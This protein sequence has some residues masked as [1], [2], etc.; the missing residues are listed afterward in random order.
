M[1]EPPVT[2]G[3]SQLT[4]EE[5]FWWLAAMTLLGAFGVVA[6]VTALEADEA[7]E[8]PAALVAV[9]LKV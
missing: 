5:A 6:G 2:T 8:T 1:A 3:A 7:S 4:D 9:T